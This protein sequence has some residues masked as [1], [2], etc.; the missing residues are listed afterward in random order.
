MAVESNDVWTGGRKEEFA[1]NP[2]ARWS[3]R[4]ARPITTTLTIVNQVSNIAAQ[5][6]SS[7]WGDFFD[8]T[9]PAIGSLSAV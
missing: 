8:G 1:P 5:G 4:Q 3:G 9:Y 2:V 7:E 6:V